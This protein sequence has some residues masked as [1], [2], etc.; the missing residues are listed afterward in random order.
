MDEERG[1]NAETSSNGADPTG[2]PVVRRITRLTLG[3]RNF[4]SNGY[5]RVKVTYDGS[6]EILEFPIRSVGI[7]EILE[8]ARRNAPQAPKR[9]QMVSG[10]T[11][12]G[13]ALGVPRGK[14]K[15]YYMFDL[16]DEDHL[17][18]MEEHERRTGFAIIDQ[19]LDVEFV[20]KAGQPVAPSEALRTMKLSVAQ[21]NDIQGSIT[22]L[23]EMDDVER[24]DFLPTS[25]TSAR[26]PA[27]PTA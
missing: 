21:F 24:A 16:T 12:V 17:K 20:D 15:P 6:P 25:S 13:R 18:A 22:R 8:A 14:S 1:A 2:R 3:E 19:G 27:T 23:T 9:M 11:D 7:A 26:T 10:D 5:C 4:Q